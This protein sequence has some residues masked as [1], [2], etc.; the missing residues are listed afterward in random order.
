VTQSSSSP[1]TSRGT[2]EAQLAHLA[3]GSP[4]ECALTFTLLVERRQPPLA[5]IASEFDQLVLFVGG[6]EVHRSVH[7]NS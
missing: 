5:E 1:P 6:G 3:Q 7:D 2:E 4:V